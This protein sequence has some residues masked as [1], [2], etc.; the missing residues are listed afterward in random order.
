[1][2][3]FAKKLNA[4]VGRPAGDLTYYGEEIRQETKV[5][6]IQYTKNEYEE[7]EIK[8]VGNLDSII[9]KDKNTWLDIEGF[10]DGEKIN[11]IGEIFNIHDLVMEDVF[12]TN[13][14][15]K[16]EEGDDYLLFV[17][18]S[19]SEHGN[20]PKSSHVVLLLKKNLVIS[21]QEEPN[22]IIEPKIER[23]RNSKGRARIKEADYLFFVFLDA[24]I[25]SY[26]TYFENL[27]EA[28]NALDAKI[29]LQ[30][31]KNHIE[32][33][34]DLKNKLTDIRK[35]LFPLKAAI[36]E[37]LSDESELLDEENLRYFSDCKDHIN[38]LI[39]YY[40]SFGEIINSLISL[41]ENN[42]NNSTN[43]IMKV[44]TIISTIFIPLTFIAGI[45][46]MNFNNV[47]ELQ[48]EHGYYFALSLMLIVGV[49]ILG[50]LRWKKWI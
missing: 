49:L 50:I 24:F 40:Q 4:K 28:T 1:M 39:E 3:V 35:N 30:T 18:K 6:L 9:S 36:N 42:L 41:N 15:P 5:R 22:L 11:K 48:W 45:Y 46:G 32:E 21:F 27:R 2:K 14:I 29:L 10:E 47:P 20:E 13:H 31:S 12:N 19:F 23:I 17:L 34:Y 8:E 44:L 37:L 7:N 33:I 26:Y 43:K 38:E 16:Y 25:D